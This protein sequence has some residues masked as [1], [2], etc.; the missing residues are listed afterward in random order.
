[1]ST[2]SFNLAFLWVHIQCPRSHKNSLAGSVCSALP[3]LA[4]PKQPGKHQ[5]LYYFPTFSVFVRMYWKWL[6]RFPHAIHAHGHLMR[7]EFA[8]VTKLNGVE[9]SVWIRFPRTC[10]AD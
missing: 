6:C 1:M 4:D 10:V 2:Q 7:K 9:V 8:R 5:T 3:P